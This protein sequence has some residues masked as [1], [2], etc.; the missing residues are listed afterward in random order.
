MSQ[1][2]RFFLVFSVSLAGALSA[3]L[4]TRADEQLQQSPVSTTT[5]AADSPAAIVPVA[6]VPVAI[7]P[8]EKHKLAFKFRPGQIVHQEISSE[9]EMTTH[10]NQDT[11]TARNSSTSRRHYRVLAVD[12]KTGI[13]DLALTIDWVRMRAAIDN[14]EGPKVEPT[15]FQSDDPK[16]HPKQFNQVLASIG[17]PA[18]LR[19]RSNGALVKAPDAKNPAASPATAG[20]TQSAT[21]QSATDALEAYLFPLPEQPVAVGET[22][23]ERFDVHLRDVDKNLVKISL[24]RAYK[25]TDVKNERAVIELRTAILTPVQDPAIAAQLIQR[26]INGKIVFDIAQGLIISREWTVE[27]TIVNPV[28]ANSSMHAKS[29]YR[30]KLLGSEA[31]ADRAASIP[32]A[33][34]SSK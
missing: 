24:Q 32:K 18:R 31:V 33:A 23:K 20:S 22:W 25:L 16:K 13:A 4:M 8:A 29:S 2:W 26:E 19:F 30:E 28:G 15:E 1:G 27:N 6:I 10:K 21:A 3:G 11:E 14:G 17:Q 34:N 12:D 7:V 9:S 5:L